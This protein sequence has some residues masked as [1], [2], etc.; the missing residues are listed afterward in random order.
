MGTNKTIPANIS[1]DDL[2][3]GISDEK[4]R[5]D[6]LA[7]IQLIKKQT[8][9]EP[10][11]WGTSI[12]GFGSYHYQYNSG[13]K[14]DA[15]VIGLASRT[16]AIVLYLSAEFDHKEELLQKLGK[17]KSGKG[18]IYIRNLNEINT[19]ILSTMITNS[20][21]FI[22]KRYPDKTMSQTHP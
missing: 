15:P 12:I 6:C 13:H 9:L 20:V 16:N 18:C 10:V 19:D 3:Q 14:G 4:R 22:K 2:L 5:N 21:N 1:I 7:L 8:G 17:H 11:V